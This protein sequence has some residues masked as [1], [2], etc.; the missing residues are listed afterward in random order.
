M[1]MLPAC[2]TEAT[3][4]GTYVSEEWIGSEKLAEAD[5][6]GF[7]GQDLAFILSVMGTI[8]SLSAEEW[9]DPI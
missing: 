1:E 9:H 7:E 5:Q 8:R 3:V 2:D 4:A 6:E